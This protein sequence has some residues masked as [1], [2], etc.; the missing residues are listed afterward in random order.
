MLKLIQYLESVAMFNKERVTGPGLGKEIKEKL[1]QGLEKF[2]FN[3]ELMFLD[4]DERKW[5]SATLYSSYSV[6]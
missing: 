5:F 2:G 1:S 4:F 3:M 6:L